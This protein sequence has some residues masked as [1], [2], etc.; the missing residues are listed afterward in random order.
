MSMRLK[1]KMRTCAYVC[2]HECIWEWMS[3]WTC[4]WVCEYISVWVWECL[5]VWVPV[6]VYV[7]MSGCLGEN[8]SVDSLPISGP[9]SCGRDTL[10]KCSK[11]VEWGQWRGWETQKILRQ[12]SPSSSCQFLSPTVSIL[13]SISWLTRVRVSF[14]P[15]L[16]WHHVQEWTFC[17]SPSWTV[18]GYSHCLANLL[19]VLITSYSLW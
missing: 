3:I 11:P 4:V 13:R 10:E 7:K 1:G 19:R 5:S 8:E 16:P 6:S 17:F 2:T 12:L 15:G 14:S 9:R 18:M